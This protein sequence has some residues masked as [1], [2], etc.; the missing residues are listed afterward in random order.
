MPCLQV[1]AVGEQG[2]V[3]VFTCAQSEKH[4]LQTAMRAH[5]R[6]PSRYIDS[7][8][9]PPFVGVDSNCNA[10]SDM[11]YLSPAAARGSSNRSRS[12]HW[13]PHSRRRTSC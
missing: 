13:Q 7:F 8:T 6:P 3:Y 2:G 9:R 10:N 1:A 5:I 12:L 4:Q 11:V